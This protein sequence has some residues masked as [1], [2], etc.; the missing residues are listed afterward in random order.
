MCYG[1]LPLL[2]M[3]ANVGAAGNAGG[4]TSD[5]AA[6]GATICKAGVGATRLPL[7]LIFVGCDTATACESSCSCLW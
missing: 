3:L 1:L 5:T 7:I 6:G 2:L 4:G